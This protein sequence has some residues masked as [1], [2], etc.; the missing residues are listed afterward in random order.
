M[1]VKIGEMKTDNLQKAI[2][3]S[4]RRVIFD[5]IFSTLCG[6]HAYKMMLNNN[7]L[8]DLY[9]VLIALFI[10]SVSQEIQ[11]IVKKSYELGKLERNSH[12]I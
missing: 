3:E 10:A 9:V 8:A 2:E 7:L 4:K 5:M 1:R 12:E 11:E 6:A